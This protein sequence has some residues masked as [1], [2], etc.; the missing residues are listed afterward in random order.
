M[1]APPV[2]VPLFPVMVLLVK[3]TALA[4]PVWVYD[5]AYTPPKVAVEEFP[6]MMLL[7]QMTVPAEPDGELDLT[8]TAVPE[9][10]PVTMLPVRVT[11]PDAPE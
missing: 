1:H 8:S 6:A 9:P 3:V 10:F 4:V 5:S 11:L 2:Y 7:A